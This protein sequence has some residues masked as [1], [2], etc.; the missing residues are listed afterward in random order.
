[1]GAFRTLS[2]TI[3]P[4]RPA[5]LASWRTRLLERADDRSAAPVLSSPSYVVELD[6]LDGVH[7]RD[8]ATGDDALLE[9]GACR[10][11]SVLDAMLLLLHLGLG[12][13]ADLDDCDAAGQLGEPLLELLA[14]EVGVGVLDLGL[15]LL[16]P[17]LD[18]RPDRRPRR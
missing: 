8:S 6:R 17:G 12:R 11:E 2:T 16:D 9:R 4:S 15:Q 10:L 3:E 5:L 14:V 7:E 1:M 13:S 18:R